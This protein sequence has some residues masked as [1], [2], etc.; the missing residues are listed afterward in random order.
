MPAIL[1]VLGLLMGSVL[2]VILAERL[3]VAYPIFLVLAGLVIAVLPGMPSIALAPELVFVVFLPPLLYKSAWETSWRDFRF[4]LRPIL[5]LS[6]GAVIFTTSAVAAVAHYLVGLS[7]PL[8]FLLG[9][10]VSPPD[11]VAASA[12]ARR[13]GL[14][15]RIVT[16]LE[17]ESLVNDATGLVAYRF[18]V[19][20]VMAGTFS[21]SSAAGQF[22]IVA[23]GGIVVGLVAGWLVYQ[24]HRR[25]EHPTLETTIT[26]LTPTVVYLLAEEIHVSGVLATVA[27]GLLVAYRESEMFGAETRITAVATWDTYSLLLNGLVFILIGLQLSGIQ[28]TFFMY[29]PAQLLWWA[30]VLG[31][32]TIVFRFVWVYPG[33]YVP[34]WVSKRIRTTDPVTSWKYPFMVSYAG[35]RGVV[36]LAAALALPLTLPSGAPFPERDLI[37]FLSFGVILITLVGPGLTM[38][39]VIRRLGLRPD[40]G[41]HLEEHRARHDAAQEALRILDLVVAEGRYPAGQLDPLR[42]EYIGRQRRHAK[43]AGIATSDSYADA[44][45]VAYEDLNQ[46]QLEL[47]GVERGV[48]T[49]LRNQRVISDEVLKK[50]E[51]DLDLDEKRMRGALGLNAAH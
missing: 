39:W 44:C 34:R 38:P 14:P 25:L 21:L 18:A 11:A 41:H 42:N 37:I 40:N 9:A 45:L 31:L 28:H 24:I 51:H 26:L 33:T 6:I 12:V 47:I 4:N 7:W 36:S 48:L 29:D 20:A 5:L 23:L 22:M 49:R 10:I 13:V 8:G 35:M 27:C 16:I 2:L 46:L 30:L 43:H 3:R 15:R 50:I 1:T 19:A 32:A 17:G